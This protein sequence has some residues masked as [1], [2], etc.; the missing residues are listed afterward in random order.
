MNILLGEEKIE[1][2]KTE[3]GEARIKSPK[4]EQGKTVW[5]ISRGVKTKHTGKRNQSTIVRKEDALPRRARGK[6]YDNHLQVVFST[7]IS[8][9]EGKFCEPEE[10]WC[11]HKN[12]YRQEKMEASNSKGKKLQIIRPKIARSIAM[13]RGSDDAVTPKNIAWKSLSGMECRSWWLSTPD[14][15][16]LKKA[17][18]R[19]QVDKMAQLPFFNVMEFERYLCQMLTNYNR[20]M[21]KSTINYGGYEIT[22]WHAASCRRLCVEDT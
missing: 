12:K 19:A 5:T 17:L 16:I 18:E 22:I 9:L 4:A 2:P 11:Y 6:R 15:H 1:S 14:T 10:H 13:A 20:H 8:I 7:S 3:Q 21:N